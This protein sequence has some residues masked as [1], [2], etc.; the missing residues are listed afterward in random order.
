M[1]AR[2]RVCQRDWPVWV[3]RG[4]QNYGEP[5]DHPGVFGASGEIGEQGCV[6]GLIKNFIA[7]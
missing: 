4:S 2:R 3:V 7:I 6:R 5:Q 1:L